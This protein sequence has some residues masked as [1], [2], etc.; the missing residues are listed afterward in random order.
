[1]FDPK[2]EYAELKHI[3]EHKAA[4][5]G[6]KFLNYDHTDIKL[7]SADAKGTII[8]RVIDENMNFSESTRKE[9]SK[10]KI[11]SLTKSENHIILGLDKKVQVT[12]VKSDNNIVIKK[13]GLTSSSDREYIKLETDSESLYCIACSKKK[14]DISFFD[15]KTGNTTLNFTCG[16]IITALKYSPNYKFL[17]GTTT[18]GCIFIWKVPQNIE[19]EIMFKLNQKSLRITETPKID[20]HESKQ[21]D[22]SEYASAS[23]EKER[24]IWKNDS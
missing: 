19:R 21:D 10:A 4:V 2:E 24:K 1:V 14:R 13:S 22:F 6:A 15:I 12:S 8:S 23:A 5:I 9:L 20:S 11:F 18:M 17:L 7:V 16:E 3:E